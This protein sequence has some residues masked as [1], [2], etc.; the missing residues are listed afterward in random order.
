M[1]VAPHPSAFNVVSQL[2][3]RLVEDDEERVSVDDS[4]VPE[5]QRRQVWNA[6]QQGWLALSI[7]QRYPIG[8]IILWK[9]PDGVL[10]P[11][12]GRQRITAI[13]QFRQNLVRTPDFEWVPNEYRAK[14]YEELTL[15]QREAFN[16][17]GLQIVQYDDLPEEQAMDIFVRLQRGTPLNKAEVRA[18]LGGRISRLVTDL[19]TDRH[20]GRIGSS[21]CSRSIRLIDGRAT[22]LSA[23]AFFMNISIATR[24]S[25]GPSWKRC[26]GRRPHH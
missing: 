7:L 21:T 16:G 22:A 2:Y 3:S 1:P 5:W 24:T 25:T 6:E 10:V 26:T 23:T 14:T 12:D 13:Q 18:A 15:R 17:Y 19:A 8:L 20:G 4:Y 11:I 9:K